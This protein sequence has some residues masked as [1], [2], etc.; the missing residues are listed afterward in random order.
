[1]LAA[2]LGIMSVMLV[3]CITLIITYVKYGNF[4][5]RKI[6]VITA[7]NQPVIDLEVSVERDRMV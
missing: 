4:C 6:P 2:L 3:V 1:M 5:C 7:D